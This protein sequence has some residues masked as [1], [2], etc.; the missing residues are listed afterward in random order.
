MQSESFLEETFRSA[1][2]NPRHRV[3]QKAAQA[4]LKALLPETGSDIKGQMRSRRE[5][6]ESSGYAN[7]PR[8]FDNLIH[9]LDPELRLITPTDPEGS[10][11]ESQQTTPTG[12]YYQL[13]HD[14]LVHSL[15]DWLT[16]K[17]WETRRGR[18]EL[19]LAERSASWNAK[20]ENRHL[21]AALEWANIRLLTKKKGWT[22]PQ[23]NMMKRAGRVHGIRGLTLASVLLLLGWGSYE[24][25]GRLQ[26]QRL[27]D[28]LLGSPLS[29][30]PSII[31]ELKPYRIWIDPLLTQAYTEAKNAGDSQKQ[32]HAALAL[33]PVDDT[34][35]PYLKERLLRADAQEISVL[36]QSLESH[37]QT[38]VAEC[39]RLLQKPTQEDLGKA[40]QAASALALYDPGSPLWEKVRIDVANRLVTENAYVV[41][42][43]IDAL[44]PVAKQLSTPLDVIFHDEKRSETERTH[45]ASALAVFVSDQ[46]DELA[47]LL[48]DATERQ[49]AALYPSVEM[50]SDQTDSLFEVELAKKPPLQRGVIPND[51]DNKAWDK[52]YKRQANAAVALIRMGQTEKLL[53]LLKHSRD[54]SLRSYLVH[55]LGPLRVQPG[56]L[57]AT[58]DKESDVSIRMAL[59]LSLGE[60]EEGRLSTDERDAW[61]KKLTNLYRIDPDPGVHGATEWLLRQWRNEDQ[62][63]A[64]DKELGKLPPPTLSVDQ[65]EASSKGNNRRWYIN[66]QGQTMVIVPAPAELQMGEGKTEYRERETNWL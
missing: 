51:L 39:W 38:L 63:K 60:Y 59:I 64:I 22:E 27:R 62:I 45:A 65:G 58:L 57:I 13:T 49:F 16:R 15:R 47:G 54:P 34:E 30:A 41:A 29:D 44:R 25:N 4:V 55:R 50:K 32:L 46:P 3:H 2:A 5:L 24:Y 10:S 26:A 36:R 9:I 31:S 23:R 28:K 56:L 61:T 37:K 52:F 20:S 43:W 12:Q 11:N 8:E 18:A 6:L 19:R 21:P 1:Q 17:Q 14:Y 42:N 35:L 40:L 66:S 48:M 7:G 33:L 53:T